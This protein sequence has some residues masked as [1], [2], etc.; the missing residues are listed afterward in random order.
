[1]NERDK[2]RVL[3]VHWVAHNCEHAEEF[4][5]WARRVADLGSEE[6]ASKL[7][8]AVQEMKVV[9]D[10]LQSALDIIGGPLEH[11]H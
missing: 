4:R 11:H 6:A 10:R 9:N 8:A 2:L 7:D 3:L 1:M 5:Q